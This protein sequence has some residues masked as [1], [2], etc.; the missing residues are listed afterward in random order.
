MAN[1]TNYKLKNVDLSSC[2][3]R[4]DYFDK[5]YSAVSPSYKRNVLWAWGSIPAGMNESGLATQV[6]DPYAVRIEKSY[7]SH[8]TSWKDFHLSSYST[9]NN[10]RLIDDEGKLFLWG[11]F[12]GIIWNA[13]STTGATCLRHPTDTFSTCSILTC[14]TLNYIIKLGNDH[15]NG[16]IVSF[17]RGCTG[18]DDYANR[19]WGCNTGTGVLGN[20][21]TVSNV[22][23]PV[24]T[25][26]GCC[27]VTKISIICGTCSGVY[28]SHQIRDSSLYYWGSDGVIAN[29]RSSPVVVASMCGCADYAKD[30]C[31]SRATLGVVLRDI[32]G[33]QDSNLLVMMGYNDKGQLGSS[34]TINRIGYVSSCFANTNPA[35]RV[36]SFS[37]GTCSSF[38]VASNGTLWAWGDN[39]F[40]QLGTNKTVGSSCPVQS[41]DT[42]DNWRYVT[43][44]S[45]GSAVAAIK[46][47]G[48]LWVWGD[49]GSV[50]GSSLASVRRSSPVQVGTKKNW[51]K[52]SIQ[53]SYMVGITEENN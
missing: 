18:L 10:A 27:P 45:I 38:A 49:V 11:S 47:D 48:T 16:D 53:C 19:I 14:A 51:V 30:Y 6:D 21:Q 12:T 40:G 39:S 15:T 42:N 7:G 24:S 13:N 28:T 1:T 22:W 32:T 50:T 37:L 44:N 26:S 4:R 41:I 8:P 35:L 29:R 52:V 9:N 46:N 17:I 2:L 25:V 23:P 20:Y 31:S 36:K 34:T 33:E 5:I 43:T 3:V